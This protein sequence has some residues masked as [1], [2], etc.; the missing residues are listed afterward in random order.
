M[1]KTAQII[2]CNACHSS[3]AWA[4]SIRTINSGNGYA[5]GMGGYGSSAKATLQFPPVS[6]SNVCI[7]CH[8][9]RENGQSII[10]GVANFS[11]ASFKN[12][13]YLGAAAVFYGNGGFQY[14]SSTSQTPY[15]PQA[16]TSKYGVVVDGTI[17]KTAAATTAPNTLP[18]LNVGDATV[19]IR[20]NWQHGRLGMNN[21]SS[22]SRTTTNAG[23]VIGTDS[24]GQCVACH[25]GPTNVHTFGAFEVAK[26]TWGTSTTQKGCYGCH[27]TEDMEEVAVGERALVDRT[28]TYFKYTL[29]LAGAEYSDGYPYFYVPG[30]TTALK[31][32]AGMSVPN[33]TG[34]ANMGSAMNLKM[35]LAEKG[36]HVHNRTFMK[37]LIFDSIQYLQTGKVSF[38]NRNQPNSVGAASDPTGLLNFTAYSTAVTPAG[39][40]LP[41]DIPSGVSGSTIS[42]SQLKG[43]I[44]RKN[45]SGNVTTNPALNPAYTRP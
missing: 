41:N 25:L 9:T 36:V 13:H 42:I 10:K 14:Y 1:D 28:L 19:G 35:L 39:G 18:A 27:G 26:A 24:D 22:A 38:T 16:Y 23:K 34:A 31:N 43:Y 45:T 7:P 33:G 40:G 30:T 32:W 15:A 8:A 11:N 3:T 21:F 6:T 44:T 4:T 2:G 20:A 37:Q 17:I 5:A 12:P 29:K